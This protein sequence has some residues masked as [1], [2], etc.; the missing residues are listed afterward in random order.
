METSKD[1]N[2]RSSD[3]VFVSYSH[4]DSISDFLDFFDGM[5]YNLVYDESLSFGEEWDLNVR[6]F[7]NN[8][9]CKGLIC[10]LSPS[11]IVSRP[12]LQELDYARIYNKNVFAISTANCS[13]E[14]LASA[15]TNT[16][17]RNVAVFIADHFPP[18]KL[19]L[20]A[21]DLRQSRGQIVNTLREW[22]LEPE[23][24]EG[25]DSDTIVIDSR[26]SDLP[27]ERNRLDMQQRGYL[28]YDFDVLREILSNFDRDVVVLDVGCS[29]GDGG[30]LRFASLP[31]I[32]KVIGIDKRRSLIDEAKEKYGKDPRFRFYNVDADTDGF[33][34]KIRAI[35]E[36]EGCDSVDFVYASLTLHLLK[37][38]SV[39]LLRLYD[40]FSEDGMIMLRE[41]D[42]SGK[43]CN[44]G[45]E[46]LTE[47]L[48]RYDR[49]TH[50]ASDRYFGMKMYK[51]LYDAGY[52]DIRM[53]YR[54]FD[55]CGKNRAQKEKM[56]EVGFGYRIRRLDAIA[57]DNPDNAKLQEEI[58]WQKDALERIHQLFIQRGFLYVNTTFVAIAGIR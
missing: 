18:N 52:T 46:L 51:L 55:T 54:Y 4:K 12:V 23:R 16:M 14:E 50:S 22:G 39:F 32:S 21:R 24:E 27:E 44:P 15:V 29:N 40:L 34:D 2:D 33:V 6:R 28:E 3:Y 25:Y 45:G 1:V 56:F 7:I 30:Y 13:V 17:E 57:R 48:R 53:K 10:I 38:P 8:D 9:R 20:N 42:D 58:A 47:L 5:H 26:L 37:S 49:I 11:S 19:Y 36:Q 41:S 31:G 43:L 35:L